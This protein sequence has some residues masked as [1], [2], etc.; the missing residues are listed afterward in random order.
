MGML[1]HEKDIHEMETSYVELLNILEQMDL[2]EVELS[3]AFDE[4]GLVKVA[5]VI[6]RPADPNCQICGR[7]ILS[8]TS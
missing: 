6:V 7:T 8:K 2:L 3:R 5:R 1:S 4:G